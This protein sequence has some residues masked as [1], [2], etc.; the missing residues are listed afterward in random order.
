MLKLT[1]MEKVKKVKEKED[2]QNKNGKMILTNQNIAIVENLH[3]GR[4]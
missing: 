2:H 3:M 4:W 1:L